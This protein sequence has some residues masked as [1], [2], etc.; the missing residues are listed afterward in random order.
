ML[1]GVVELAVPRRVGEVQ[2]AGPFVP[3]PH[4]VRPRA[5]LREVAAGPPRQQLLHRRRGLF[6]QKALHDIYISPQLQTYESMPASF[7]N[8]L[9][10][11]CAFVLDRIQAGFQLPRRSCTPCSAPPCPMRRPPERSPPPRRGGREQAGA[12]PSFACPY[13]RSCV[14]RWDSPVL[15]STTLL[16]L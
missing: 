5:R 1:T 7:P 4:R 8:G 12:R 3:E 6:R 10:L 2:G 14:L 16:V 15:T 11:L 13:A 9:A